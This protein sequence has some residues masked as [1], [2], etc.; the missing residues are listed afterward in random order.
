MTTGSTGTIEWR[1][2][3][4]EDAAAVRD[5]YQSVVGWTHSPISMGDYDD[6]AMVTPEGDTIAGICHA[7]GSNAELPPQ[8]LMYIAVADLDESLAR[9]ESLG[10]KIISGPRS[11]GS[12]R[13]CIIGDPAGAAVALYQKG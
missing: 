4:V 6:Y 12:D 5:F 11:M 9:S 7:R 2:L 3:T 13:Y 8:W 1:D 10:G